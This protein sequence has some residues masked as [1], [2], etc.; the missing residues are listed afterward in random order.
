MSD[1]RTRL[2]GAIDTLRGLAGVTIGPPASDAMLERAEQ[3]LGRALPEQLR[4]LLSVTN[5]LS[6]RHGLNQILGVERDDA[7]DLVDF[8]AYDTW[9]YAWPA[10]DLADQL[11]FHVRYDLNVTAYARDGRTKVNGLLAIP[12]PLAPAR[13]DLAR[14][15]E[16][17]WTGMAR[18][19]LPPEDAA[20]HARLG[21]LQPGEGVFLGPRFFLTGELDPAETQ[22]AP[23]V[24]TLQ[25]SGGLNR[26]ADQLPPNTLVVAPTRE[27]DEDGRDQWRWVTDADLPGLADL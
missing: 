7:P 25:M 22:K 23:L 5:G 13:T 11:V 21:S 20:V 12:Q 6:I 17:G 3:R 4:V 1:I 8:N 26:D 2:Q 19:P 18:R 14:Q 16:A 24:Q 27:Q 15:I 10:N 9:K